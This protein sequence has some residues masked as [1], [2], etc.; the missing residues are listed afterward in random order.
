MAIGKKPTAAT[1]ALLHDA[2]I[3]DVGGLWVGPVR[4]HAGV[5]LRHLNVSEKLGGYRSH[6]H[7]PSRIGGPKGDRVPGVD[8]EFDGRLRGRMVSGLEGGKLNLELGSEEE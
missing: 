4:D 2:I 3:E 6:H 1:A 5:V 7:R 8:A